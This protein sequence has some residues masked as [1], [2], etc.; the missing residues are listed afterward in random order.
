[1]FD[2]APRLDIPILRVVRLWEREERLT[3]LL[4]RP[5]YSHTPSE[6]LAP[7]AAPVHSGVCSKASLK[8]YESSESDESSEDAPLPPKKKDVEMHAKDAF[9]NVLAVTDLSQ[10][11]KRPRDVAVEKEVPKYLAVYYYYD[12]KDPGGGFFRCSQTRDNPQRPWL[13]SLL[14]AEV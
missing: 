5:Q 9:F 3:E 11:K 6:A 4:G 7:L 10:C 2:L 13:T 8:I 12:K 14:V 1:M